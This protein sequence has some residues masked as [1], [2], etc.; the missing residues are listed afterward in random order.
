[1]SGEVFAED[2]LVN[3]GK[4]S[5]LNGIVVGDSPVLKS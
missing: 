4:L 3:D 5:K 2:V 1:M